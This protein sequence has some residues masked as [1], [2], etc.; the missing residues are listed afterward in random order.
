MP[1]VVVAVEETTVVTMVVRITL[2]NRDVVRG[3][4]YHNAHQRNEN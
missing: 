4:C 1:P 3:R 2:F